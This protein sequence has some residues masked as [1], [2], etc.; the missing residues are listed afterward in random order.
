M[1]VQEAVLSTEYV[2]LPF[3]AP[4]GVTV[5][6]SPTSGSVIG[7]HTVIE[8]PSSGIVGVVTNVPKMGGVLGEFVTAK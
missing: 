8:P 2:T 3:K 6:V 1:G 4:Q 5:C 7:K